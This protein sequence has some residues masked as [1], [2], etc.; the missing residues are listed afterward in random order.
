MRSTTVCGVI[1]LPARG[2]WRPGLTNPGFLITQLL[3]LLQAAFRGLDY[4]S[5]VRPGDPIQRAVEAAAP[6]PLWGA[7]FYGL[8]LLVIIGV[9]G[10]WPGVM[11]LG[12]LAFAALYLG[13]GVLVLSTTAEPSAAGAVGL[14]ACGAGTW[15]LLT[16]R[17]ATHAARLGIAL[18]LL[19][20]GQLLLAL[21]LGADYR[22]GTGFVLS[23]VIHAAL[24]TG[25]S[26]GS[27][28]QRADREEAVRG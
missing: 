1:R 11:I 22:T 18:P 10:R 5:G 23:G 12:H 21:S 26:W 17:L 27:A 13:I 8:A 7:L 25:V 6:Y 20:G 9:A 15:A 28:K 3:L 19:I 14:L 16:G 24:A 4:L 2:A